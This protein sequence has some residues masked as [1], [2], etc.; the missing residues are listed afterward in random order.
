L[1]EFVTESQIPSSMAAALSPGR[2]SE[3]H[4][5]S[6]LRASDGAL[7]DNLD[8]FLSPRSL[9]FDG[10]NMWVGEYGSLP[11]ESPNNTVTKIRVSDDAALGTF[12]VHKRP[13]AMA[14]D[15]TDIWW[16]A[17]VRAWSTAC[18]L[19]MAHFGDLHS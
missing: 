18:K 8:I 2:T 19:A 6:K 4:D 3:G 12:G 11:H 1:E 16:R 14:F 13:I 5:P 7:L 10:E 15:G 9:A 17:T